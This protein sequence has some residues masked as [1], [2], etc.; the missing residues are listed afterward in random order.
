MD[1]VVE[2]QSWIMAGCLA[3]SQ[4][5]GCVCSIPGFLGNQFLDELTNRDFFVNLP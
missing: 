3:G 2:F 1:G 5:K 4:L